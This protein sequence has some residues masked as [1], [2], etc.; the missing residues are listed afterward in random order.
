M[1]LNGDLAM[2]RTLTPLSFLR[3]SRDLIALH[4]PLVAILNC[5]KSRRDNKEKLHL[6]QQSRLGGNKNSPLLLTRP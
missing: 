1:V 2:A 5:K 4:K 3:E 6:Q